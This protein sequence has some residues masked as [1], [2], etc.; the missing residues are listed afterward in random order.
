MKLDV[1]KIPSEPKY[2]RHTA[3]Y[4]GE[5]FRRYQRKRHEW[6]NAINNIKGAIDVHNSCAGLSC[7][8][9]SVRGTWGKTEQQVWKQFC[10]AMGQLK[11]YGKPAL[12]PVTDKEPLARDLLKICPWV[13]NVITTKSKHG[14]YNAYIFTVFVE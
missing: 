5:A 10:W 3:P 2:P 7:A 14:D 9:P 8:F 11:K 1:I 4:D 13:T 6:Y 12:I